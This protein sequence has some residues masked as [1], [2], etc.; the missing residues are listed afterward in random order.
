MIQIWRNISEKVQWK[1][2]DPKNRFFDGLE[3]LL[4]KTVFQYNLYFGAFFPLNFPLDLKLAKS[5]NNLIPKLTYLE[6][7]KIFAVRRNFLHFLTRKYE[8]RNTKA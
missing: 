7:R 8:I 2:L 3:F 6:K 5:L 4:E 1:K